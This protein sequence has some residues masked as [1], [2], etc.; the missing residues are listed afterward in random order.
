MG[1]RKRRKLLCVVRTLVMGP[2]CRTTALRGK[3]VLAPFLL[4]G[5]WLLD[6]GKHFLNLGGFQFLER[7]RFDLANPLP[8]HREALS[9]LLQRAG[10]FVADTEAQ[11][12][13]GLLSG[14]E[15]TENALKLVRQFSPVHMGIGWDGVQVWEQFPEFRVSVTYR[16]LQGDRF[17]KGLH[18]F[19]ESL[20]PHS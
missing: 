4:H 3:A 17:L 12:D 1:K 20:R 7:L 9:H 14:R 2:H 11:P 15:P 5:L 10:L 6:G 19:V 13:D 18:G 16:L 8:R